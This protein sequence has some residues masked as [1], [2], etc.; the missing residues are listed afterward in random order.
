MR[1]SNQ[2]SAGKSLKCLFVGQKVNCH[3]G[4]CSRDWTRPFSYN[5]SEFF[6]MSSIPTSV[7]EGVCVLV[8][9]SGQSMDFGE[10]GV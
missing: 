5:R 6:A 7:L 9:W 4:T 1:T 10:Y 8:V 3:L 2:L